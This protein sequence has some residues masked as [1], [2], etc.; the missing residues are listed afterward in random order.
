[1]IKIGKSLGSDFILKDWKKVIKYVLLFIFIFLATFCYT[2]F[3]LWVVGDEIWNY[4]VII[5]MLD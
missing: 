4:G 2:N 3:V 1:M 5:L